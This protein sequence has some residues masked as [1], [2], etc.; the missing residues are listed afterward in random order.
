[1]N[2]SEQNFVPSTVRAQLKETPFWQPMFRPDGKS[3]L[4]EGLE[5][6]I[7][8]FPEIRPA[9]PFFFGSKRIIEQTDKLLFSGNE[10][11]WTKIRFRTKVHVH[12]ALFTFGEKKKETDE[13]FITGK[14]YHWNKQVYTLLNLYCPQRK[15]NKNRRSKIMFKQMKITKI[16]RNAKSMSHQSL[17]ER[18]DW[19]E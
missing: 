19:N 7:L 12:F 11:I 4:C 8:G 5:M 15:K 2:H 16:Q 3:L 10:P 6:F 14:V 13:F 17:W 1:M 18:N 9:A